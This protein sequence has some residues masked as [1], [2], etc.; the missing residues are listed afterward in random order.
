MDSSHVLIQ[1]NK[2]RV[3]AG[4]T[5]IEFLVTIF[6]FAITLTLAIP[7]FQTFIMNA[8]LS[9]Q[10]NNLVNALNYARN[11]ALSQIQPIQVC[12]FSA[13]NST[14]CGTSWAA[15]WIIMTQPATGTPVLLQS[16]QAK[17]TGPILSATGVT[18]ITFS[19]RGLASN[20]AN[21]KLCDSR[22]ASFARSV[23]LL[24]TGFV[25]I[26]ATA[27]IAAWDGSVLTCP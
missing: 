20:V 4:F 16:Y 15:G 13:L 19:T 18:G 10:A 22:G 27:G 14:T 9:A 8:R 26:G 2:A 6:V 1:L 21:F 5:F 25:Q 23:A 11:T 12:P 7:A 17:T 24:A 3:A